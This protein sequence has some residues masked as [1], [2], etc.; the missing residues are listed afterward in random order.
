MREKKE[1]K[2]ERREG[3][4]WSY[5][6][7]YPSP[8]G[9]HT[10]SLTHGSEASSSKSTGQLLLNTLRLCYGSFQ[11]PQSILS[12]HKTKLNM[13]RHLKNA[14]STRWRVESKT[15]RYSL[16]PNTKNWN[17]IT[18]I[19]K[20]DTADFGEAAAKH[21]FAFLPVVWFLYNVLKWYLS[22]MFPHESHHW[23]QYTVTQT[24]SILNFLLKI[25]TIQ[26]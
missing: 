3:G 20:A 7:V 21:R 5:P 1:R 2:R 25:T 14:Q 11:S 6:V 22:N 26:C 18:K 13:H 10:L 24:G 4:R 16:Q 23:T 9:Q 12:K 17:K 8:L 15:K 19:K